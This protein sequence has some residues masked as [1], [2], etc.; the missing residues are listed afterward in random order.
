MNENIYFKFNKSKLKY[1]FNKYKEVGNIYYPLKTN[2]NINVIRELSK[3]FRN[4]DG[5]LISTL[6]HFY[7]LNSI[8]IS[9]E[10]MCCINVLASDYMLKKLY[11]NGVRFFVFDDYDTLIRFSSYADL[12]KVK[13]ALRLNLMEIFGNELMHLGASYEEC[14]EM[15]N[16]L[17]GKCLE[18]GISFYIQKRLKNRKNVLEDIVHY[19]NSNFND[20][21]F[22]S[23]AGFLEEDIDVLKNNYFK[24]IIL[25]PGKY[26]VEDVIDLDTS[27]IRKKKIK[28][29]NILI[30]K[31]GIYSGMFDVLLYKKE[32]KMYLDIDG[33]KILLS[34]KKINE[35]Y[36]DIHLFG[37]SSDSGDYLGTMFIAEEYLS[38][39]NCKTKII[40]KNVGAYFEEFFMNYGNNLKKI[41]IE[42]E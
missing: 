6:D 25:E 1:N 30:I 11:S 22:I 21:D 20:L 19:I 8:N 14:L 17:R 42:E 5:F 37:G 16:F 26:L 3:I 7:K 35:S 40:I 39:I 28:N 13:I 41:Y 23:V 32:F 4:D 24:K 18:I 36:C 9:P 10:K 33:K 38:G 31:N 2:S 15:F 27:V 12:S 34:H 29:K